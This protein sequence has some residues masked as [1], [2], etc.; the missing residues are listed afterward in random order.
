MSKAGNEGSLRVNQQES[1]VKRVKQI[2]I[3]VTASLTYLTTTV[4]KVEK[5]WLALD[6]P[7]HSLSISANADHFVY[8]CAVLM[9]FFCN[10]M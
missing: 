6:L 1:V 4:D 8:L 9:F 7:F 2:T 10:L 3:V 5:M